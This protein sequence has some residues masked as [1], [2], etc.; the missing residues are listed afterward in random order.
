MLISN[1]VFRA[2]LDNTVECSYCSRLSFVFSLYAKLSDE[3]GQDGVDGMEGHMGRD[4]Q[5]ALDKKTTARQTLGVLIHFTGRWNGRW[6][7]GCIQREACSASRTDELRRTILLWFF[8]VN[9]A[10]VSFPLYRG[11]KRRKTEC[12]PELANSTGHVHEVNGLLKKNIHFINN[13]NNTF[14]TFFTYITCIPGV[15][16]AKWKMCD[17]EILEELFLPINLTDLFIVIRG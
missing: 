1:N 4:K 15:L 16:L 6:S 14:S 7:D 5:G 8:I 11:G 9:N 13:K 10:V 2:A 12:P 3:A 17:V